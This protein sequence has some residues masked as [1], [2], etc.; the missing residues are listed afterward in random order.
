MC[1]PDA[2]E[3][4]LQMQQ[5]SRFY[6]LLKELETSFLEGKRACCLKCDSGLQAMAAIQIFGETDRFSCWQAPSLHPLLGHMDNPRSLTQQL[7]YWLSKCRNLSDDCSDI[8]LAGSDLQISLIG[9][10]HTVNNNQLGLRARTQRMTLK[11]Q[12]VLRRNLHDLAIDHFPICVFSR[13]ALY[14]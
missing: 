3:Q 2:A 5:A 9:L 10:A 1:L 14:H 13:Q 4:S 8:F 11:W 6:L 12:E 7:L